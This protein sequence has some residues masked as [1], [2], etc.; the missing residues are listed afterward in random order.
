MIERPDLSDDATG[1][2]MNTSITPDEP[3]LTGAPLRMSGQERWGVL[4]YASGLLFL[5]GL[6][7]PYSG[8]IDIPIQF[9]LKNRLHLSAPDVATF[10]LYA[11]IP[12][13]VTV[14]F[15]FTRDRL[16][17]L[18]RRDRGF[19]IVFGLATAAIFTAL[20][21]TP[22]SYATLLG[23]VVIATSSF[24][25]IDMAKA[26][27]LGTLGQQ[28]S[29]SGWIS[30]V[31]NVVESAPFIISFFLGGQL[32]QTLEQDSTGAAARALFLVGAAVMLVV[33]AYGW[34][35]PKAVFDHLRD[36]R[37]TS[38][39][40]WS[41]VKRLARSWPIYPALLIW[42]L[43]DFAPG[44]QTV[45]Q[46]YV[47]N[48]LHASDAVWGNYNALFVA[49][50]IPTFLLY[51]WLCPRFSLRTLLIWGTV[52][53]APQMMPLLFIHSPESVEAAGFGLGLLGGVCSAAYWDLIIRSCPKG[54]QASM[55]GLTTAV[56]WLAA[57]FGD[58][59]GTDLYKNH[60]GFVTCV[61]VTTAVYF[62]ILPVVWW[63]VPG[64]LVGAK[65][66]EVIA[67]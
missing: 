30:V 57:R 42:F 63:M 8:L 52:V 5:C 53:G 7:R 2:R 50:F 60:G 35:R 47:S 61:W 65:E 32:S 51:G 26:G 43:W 24:L 64:R 46:F 20:A 49:G 36:E 67:A 58:L 17:P 40:P 10:R 33:A 38:L 6:S 11:G 25:L 9:F 41:D 29:M 1:S 19:M 48:E 34:L 28:Q 21:F 55:F 12:L 4:A 22:V 37:Q 44:T 27:L 59:W 18:G 54:L 15:G 56:Y 66:G 13:Y 62:L 16:N 45:M 23:G 31:W 39:T 14:I 3:Q